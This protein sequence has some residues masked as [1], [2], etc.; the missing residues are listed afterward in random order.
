MEDIILDNKID[1]W[2]H[3]HNHNNFEYNIGDTKVVSNCRGYGGEDSQN[4]EI[5]VITV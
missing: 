5:K 4:F 1:Y 2:I 3:G